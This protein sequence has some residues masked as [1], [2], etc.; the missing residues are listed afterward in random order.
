[1]SPASPNQPAEQPRDAAAGPNLER[2]SSGTD[3]SSVPPLPPPPRHSRRTVLL[4]AG[5]G[6]VAAAAAGFGVGRAT[7]S[8]ASD[9]VVKVRIGTTEASEPY[10]PVLKRL[11]RDEGI[12][13]TTVQFDDYTQANPALA[14]EQID[15]NLFQHLQFLAEYDSAEDQDLKPVGS[16][17]V[18]PLPLYSRKHSRLSEIPD[19][20]TV[21]IPNDST[22]QARA[23]LVLQQAKL[24]TL[25]GG[26]SSTSTP[27]DV[28]T[29]ASKVKITPVAA[30]QTAT[31]LSSV[32]GAVVNNNYALRAKLSTKEVLYQD[33]PTGKAAEP[34]INVLVS[35]ADDVD[36]ETYRTILRLYHE[37]EVEKAVL[38][39]SNDTAVIVERPRA[40][41]QKILDRL[42]EQQGRKDD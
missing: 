1:M 26:G 33:K 12:E 11:A 30:A 41:L 14:Q 13:I 19:G 24:I 16:T 17:L 7:A 36:N 21:T 5:G 6:L 15:L 37:P 29:A 39:A 27:A 38:S 8:S 9:E 4:A 34:Y 32:D 40:Q 10:W 28:D 35:R 20:G 25:K 22:N 2:T 23:L 42:I 3:W 31:S 18:V